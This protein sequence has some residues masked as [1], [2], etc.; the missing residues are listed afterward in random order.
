MNRIK[1]KLIN[2]LFNKLLK[3]LNIQQLKKLDDKVAEYL[4]G[5]FSKHLVPISALHPAGCKCTGVDTT[6][7]TPW[8]E[9]CGNQ[10][11][12]NYQRIAT[13]IFELEMMYNLIRSE[14]L[15]IG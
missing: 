12:V 15:I 5:L 7:T 1:S 8:Y 11:E 6:S 2:T 9:Q 14:V 10:P 4:P 13:I 3:A